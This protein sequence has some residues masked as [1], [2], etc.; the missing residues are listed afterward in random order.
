MSATINSADI[1]HCLNLLKSDAPDYYLADLLLPDQ[2]RDAVIV[3]H[4]FHVEIT[5]ITLSVGEPMAGQ[6]RLQWWA[7]VLNGQ[8]SEEA[9]GHPVARALVNVVGQ[10]QLPVAS[11]EAKLEAHI[12]DL[13]Q[14]PMGNRTAF[15][16]YCG[17]TRSCLFQWAALILGAKPGTDLA[18]ASG[19]SGVATG[20]V[21][22]IEQIG[23][24]H[25][26]GQVYV[27]E[28]LLAAVG[29]TPAHYLEPPSAKHQTVIGA[30]IDLAR[31][32][33][34]K[35]IEALGQL[36][37]GAKVAFKPLALVPL[38]LKRAERS[39]L[40]VFKRRSDI[41]QFRHQWALWRF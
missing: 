9:M 5:N 6:M 28:E 2:G 4:A 27:P 13:Y 15:E 32:H 14:D 18:N 11:F 1:A 19:H 36:P 41:S 10:Y 23:Q 29:L 25:N 3:L 20:I 17:E 38:Y 35:A 34:T 12:F 40:D 7:E 24:T 31:E 21:S 22:L 30:L 8:R 33:E 39:G 37:D 16:A 26:N